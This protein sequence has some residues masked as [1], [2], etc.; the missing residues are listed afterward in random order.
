MKIILIGQNETKRTKYFLLAAER[1]R[2]RVET[3]EMGS[4]APE[5]LPEATVKIDPPP[6]RGTALSGLNA[7]IADYAAFLGALAAN[8]KL[9]F[10]NEPSAILAALDKRQVKRRLLD[11]R[12][13]TP[14][15][16]SGKIRTVQA[17]RERLRDAG[18]N[19]FFLKPRFGSGAAAVIACS[20]AR[21]SDKLALYTSA[22]FSGGALVNTKK[23]RKVE[24]KGEAEALLQAVLNLDAVA[25]QWIPKAAH[26]GAA[27]DLRAVWQFGRVARVVARQS[28]SPI[29]NLHLNNRALP[30]G[31]LDL[32]PGKRE[33]IETLCARA[34]ALYPGL[35]CAGID[36]LL[37]KH[38]LAPQIIEINGQGDLIY[39]DIHGENRIYREQLAMMRKTETGGKSPWKKY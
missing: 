35:R 6:A 14:T 26:Q 17:L 37:E 32:P 9:R 2:L 31:A 5:D 34:M 24:A 21:N 10:L 22:A 39:L 27:Y 13:A 11:A 29:T 4:F 38:T 20:L 16:L 23:I 36:I 15:A 8:Q 28:S 12:I 19:R 33:E 18:L 3:R 30:V 7:F 25:E 1:V